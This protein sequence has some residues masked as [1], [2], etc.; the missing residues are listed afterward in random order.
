ME[1]V[2]SQ[3]SSHRR[4]LAKKKPVSKVGCGVCGGDNAK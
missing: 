4:K 2:K 3:H 1:E